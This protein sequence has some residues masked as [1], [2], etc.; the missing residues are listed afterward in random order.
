M[1]IFKK[2][3]EIVH[4]F[5]ESNCS[6]YAAG[7]TYFTLLS[8]IPIL[9]CILVLAK[10]CKVDHYAREQINTRIDAMITN[11]EKGQDDNLV[12]LA[13][14]DEKEL[15]KK[16]IA[17]EE[18]AT[19]ARAISNALFKR[20][21][22][23]D[24]GTLG[25]IGF[26]MLLWT[27]VSAL[28]M[29]EVSLNRIWGVLKSRPIWK[30]MYIYLLLM[31]VLPLVGAVAMSMPILKIAKN[32]IVSTLGATW[33]TKWAG[34]GLVWFIDWWGF[35]LLITLFFTSLMFGLLFWVIPNCAVKF[36]K[37]FYG[38][39]LTALLFGGWVKLCAIAQIGIAKSSALYGSFAILPIVLAWLY[40]SWQIVLFGACI[41]KTLHES[42]SLSLNI[43]IEK[44]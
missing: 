1:I 30:R 33:L 8:I 43:E 22:N 42:L 40:M 15:E 11:I 37:A 36:K 44:K 23:F 41:V 24:I 19:Q 3:L 4:R 27:V 32:V 7:L 21:D 35:R 16:R 34:D 18:F 28:G 2:A 12:N 31:I 29:V 26:G 6:M 20:I 5:L 10:T 39:I 25:W 9:C 14:F 38:G 17:A 13:K